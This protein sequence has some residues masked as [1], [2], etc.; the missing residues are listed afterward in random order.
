MTR[1]IIEPENDVRIL[2][3]WGNCGRDSFT[4]F[5]WNCLKYCIINEGPKKGPFMQILITNSRLMELL[6]SRAPPV[7][8]PCYKNTSRNMVYRDTSTTTRACEPVHTPG[9]RKREVFTGRL[10][11]RI[12]KGWHSAEP[13]GTR[14]TAYSHGCRDATRRWCIHCLL[15]I[16]LLC[17]SNTRLRIPQPPCASDGLP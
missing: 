11:A 13:P 6:P 14:P 4:G 5:P 1:I 3:L 16:R 17:L 10:T 9:K 2:V 7:L 8:D 15:P 12:R